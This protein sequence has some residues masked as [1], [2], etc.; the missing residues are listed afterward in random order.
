MSHGSMDRMN[1]KIE[2]Y[3]TGLYQVFLVVINM[4]INGVVQQKHK[5]KY[6]YSKYISHYITPHLALHG[7]V[8]YP[9]CMN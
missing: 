5:G 6:I 4:K 2:A 8:K 9:K 3:T 1:D 7:M